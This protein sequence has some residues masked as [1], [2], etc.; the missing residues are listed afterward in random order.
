[1][2]AWREH[3]RRLVAVGLLAYVAI[4]GGGCGSPAAR[5]VPVPRTDRGPRLEDAL[6]DEPPFLFV[7]RPAMLVRDPLYGPLLRRVSQLAAARAALADV[8]GST[9]LAILERTDEVAVAV[10]DREAGDALVLLR[11]VPADADALR[12]VD[13]AGNRLWT[14]RAEIPGR[15]EE[16]AP[17]DAAVD[18][19]LFVLPRRAWAIAVGAAVPRARVSYARDAARSGAAV[20]LDT[21]DG[22]LATARVRGDVLARGRSDGPL[23]PVF[24]A[25]DVATVSLEPGPQG[26]VGEVVLRLVYGAPAFATRAEP[27]VADVVAAY[28]RE[29]GARAPW[30]HAVTVSRD[31]RAVVVKGRIPRAW[32][33]GLLHVELGDLAN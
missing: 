13:T 29:L 5:S 21:D 17:A 27:S 1:M 26:A 31:D 30:L 8:V 33:E 14:L 16:L 10:Y 3:A 25:L 11:G 28:T 18:A 23:A 12:I 19:E 32:T 2:T 24:Q 7:V 22:V 6:G 9:M 20:S 4:V 15:V